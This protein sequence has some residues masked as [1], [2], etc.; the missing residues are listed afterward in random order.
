MKIDLLRIHPLLSLYYFFTP[1]PLLKEGLF[2]HTGVIL[3]YFAIKSP[4]RGMDAKR[5]GGIIHA[6]GTT[7]AAKKTLLFMRKGFRMK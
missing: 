5:P 3:L 7:L 4:F 6:I 2:L 1:P